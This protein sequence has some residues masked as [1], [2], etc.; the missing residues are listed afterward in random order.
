M[1]KFCAVE[2]E[3]NFSALYIEK[4]VRFGKTHFWRK[5]FLGPLSSLCGNLYPIVTEDVGRKDVLRVGD[6]IRRFGSVDVIAAEPSW[7]NVPIAIVW[8]FDRHH[9][10][11]V[12][13]RHGVDVTA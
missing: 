13:I 1:P 12:W 10:C 11:I 6:L 7:I 9:L 4:L 2:L 5:Q 8:A 3:R